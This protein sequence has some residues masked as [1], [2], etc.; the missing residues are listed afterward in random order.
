MTIYTYKV[1]SFKKLY[2]I[3]LVISVSVQGLYGP[4]PVKRGCVVHCVTSEKQGL[5]ASFFNGS[6]Q[7]RYP[8]DDSILNKVSVILC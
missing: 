4:K 6:W 2:G 8:I 7:T 1:I 3:F 5:L